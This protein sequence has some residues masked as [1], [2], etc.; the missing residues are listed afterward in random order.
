M[1]NATLWHDDAGYPIQAH[2]GWILPIDGFYYWYGEDRSE[3]GGFRCYRSHD[4]MAWHDCGCVLA[5]DVSEVMERPRVLRCPSTGKFVLWFYADDAS[6]GQ[7]NAGFA[8][9][10]APEGPFELRRVM[11]PNGEDC[12]GLTLFQDGDG[13]VWLVFASEGNASLHVACLAPDCLSVDK[14]SA[15]VLI[16]QFRESPCVF[17]AAGQY[18]LVS[19]GCTGWRA[20]QALWSTAA[21]VQGPW[22]LVGNPCEGITPLAS[23]SA[24]FGGQITCVF[25]GGGRLL[26]LVDYWSPSDLA[27][28]GYSLLP[29]EVLHD[30][31]RALRIHWQADMAQNSRGVVHRSP[32]AVYRVMMLT[33]TAN[34]AD[35]QYALAHALLSPSFDVRGVV[36]QHFGSSGS[37]RTSYDEAARVMD[38]IDSAD[39]VPL[40]MGASGSLD[41]PSFDEGQGAEA[42][43]REALRDDDR[44][45]Y[46]LCI[47]HLTDVVLA[48]RLDPTVARRLVVV[49]V[50]GG[51]YPNGSH[52]ANCARDVIA[53]QEVF[54]SHVPLWQIPSEAYKMLAV[55][56]AEIEARVRPHGALGSY[57][58]EELDDFRA[59]NLGVKKWVLPESWVLG[60]QAAVGVLLAEQKGCYEVRPAPA[61]LDDCTYGMPPDPTRTIRVYHSL[62][63][64]LILE[65]LY[66]KLAL[67]AR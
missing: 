56:A 26:A 52:E 15:R 47:G 27:A 18:Y 38:L 50:G 33:D 61:L 40:L 65:D 30:K 32:G 19:S 54:R 66:C 24:T 8:V 49:W 62:D 25:H 64:R 46:L 17:T 23:A 3:R 12:R 28:S 7:G 63:T 21:R 41:S 48:L 44:P 10:D 11:R 31:H 34:K 60:D 20:N 4:L 22:K 37:T 55:S 13:A 9:A 35:D 16:D 5:A 6:Y 53:A 59:R 29:V 1:R 14:D 57:L 43:V 67:H 45:L 42:I 36:A 58:A 51:R 2:G 39:G